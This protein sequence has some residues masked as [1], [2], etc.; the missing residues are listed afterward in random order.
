MLLRL[1]PSGPPSHVASLNL[2]LHVG[3][4]AKRDCPARGDRCSLACLGVPAYSLPFL[5][6]LEYAKVSE[7]PRAM[8]AALPKAAVFQG[9]QAARIVLKVASSHKS[10]PENGE[11]P[12]STTA[13]P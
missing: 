12:L 13:L 7:L 5:S 8:P 11:L 4:G 10:I 3:R 6:D 9:A 2:G 1:T